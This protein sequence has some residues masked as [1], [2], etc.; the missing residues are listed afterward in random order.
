MTTMIKCQMG[1]NSLHEQIKYSVKAVRPVTQFL[2][3]FSFFLFFFSFFFCFFFGGRGGREI[4]VITASVKA[5]C[6]TL[7]LSQNRVK[8][9]FFSSIH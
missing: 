8:D 1:K 7:A 2:Q 9:L 3:V 4:R 5:A 6:R